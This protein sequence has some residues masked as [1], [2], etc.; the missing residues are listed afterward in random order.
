M[1]DKVEYESDNDWAYDRA[2][3]RFRIPSD[4]PAAFIAFDSVAQTLIQEQ[5][6]MT[7]LEVIRFGQSL[8][9]DDSCG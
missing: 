7:L 3:E 2:L 9:Y 8:N 5:G 1:A 4:Y 6:L